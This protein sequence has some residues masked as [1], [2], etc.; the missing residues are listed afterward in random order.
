VIKGGKEMTGI[1]LAGSRVVVVGGSSG[2]GKAVAKQALDAGAVVTIGSRSVD[3]LASAAADLGGVAWASI[4]VTS[5]E[6]VRAFFE[7]IDSLD[8]L[9]VCP[10]D[11]ASG[12][13]FDVPMEQVRS[14]LDTKIVGQMLC[15]RH[16]ARKISQNGSVVLLSGVAGYRATPGLSVTSAANAAI[17]AMGRSLAL[18]LAPI[19]VNVVVAG[20]IDTPIWSAVP[21]EV[22]QAIFAQTVKDTPVGRIGEPEDVAFSVLHALENTFLSGALLHVDGGVLIA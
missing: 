2:I 17:G 16:G 4:D 12:T 3:K 20:V 1:E 18:E 6:S 9:I 19:R 15:V 7:Q 8:H 10:G 11:L 13:V 22:R 5:E 21:D 14:C